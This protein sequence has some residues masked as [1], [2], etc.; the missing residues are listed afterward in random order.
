MAT[1]TVSVRAVSRSIIACFGKRSGVCSRKRATSLC[2]IGL[3][4]GCA[5]IA[6]RLSPARSEVEVGCFAS[7]FARVGINPC[8]GVQF[9]NTLSGSK[10]DCRPYRPS[11]N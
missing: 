5:F 7:K 9:L 1:V 6:V 10:G 11:S 3:A 8:C 2:S 4:D